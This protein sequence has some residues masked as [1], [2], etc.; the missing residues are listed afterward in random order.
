VPRLARKAPRTGDRPV[1]LAKTAGLCHICGGPAGAKWHADHVLP[2]AKGGGNSADN[3]LP[4]CGQCNRLRWHRD[5]EEIK[6]I[7]QLGIYAAQQIRQDSQL[8]RRIEDFVKKK[9][10][11]NRKRRK[12]WR[13]DE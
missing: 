6:E 11:N 9:R 1:I 5:P 10:E 7:L 13:L 8:G 3:Y 12:V 2:L 4:A